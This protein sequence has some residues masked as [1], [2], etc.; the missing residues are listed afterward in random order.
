MYTEAAYQSAKELHHLCHDI[1]S[2]Y[3]ETCI[4]IAVSEYIYIYV[5]V[6][7]HMN[8]FVWFYIYTYIYRYI[9]IYAYAY[10]YIY[11]YIYTNSMY[12]MALMPQ[13]EK[14]EDTPRRRVAAAT[15]TKELQ[16]LCPDTISLYIQTCID[17]VVSEYI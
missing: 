12:C 5:P 2:L 10:N 11:V 13:E 15:A 3:T 7:T 1:I 14:S 9:Y 8:I 16:H 4:Y 6:S 17:I